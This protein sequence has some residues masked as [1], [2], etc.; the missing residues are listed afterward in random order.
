M[1][2][3]RYDE[4]GYYDCEVTCQ[5]DPL[6]TEQS[7][8]EVWLLPADSTWEKPLP[9]KEGYYVVWNGSSWEYEEIP[10]PPVPP[11]PT[12]DDMKSSVRAMRNYYL[13]YWDFTQLIDAPFTEDE[14]EKYREYRQYLRDYTEQD[15]WW[16]KNPDDWQTWLVAHYPV[17]E[18]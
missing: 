3:Y 15:N 9:E 1:I 8:K 14:R 18:E 11:E 12:E 16:L 17:G 13:S 2:A 4:K 6:E 5:L 10:E 7:G